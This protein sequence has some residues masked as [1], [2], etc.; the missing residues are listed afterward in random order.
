MDERSPKNTG[1]PLRLTS[2]CQLEAK[3]IS[4]AAL[5]EHMVGYALDLQRLWSTASDELLVSLCRT[6][7]GLYRYGM[8][9]EAAAEAEKKMAATP[10]SH[11]PE[12]PDPVKAT[13]ARLLTDGATLERGFQ[14]VLDAR[15]QHDMWVEAEL[16]EETRQQWIALLA[17]LPRELQAAGV[18]ETSRTMMRGNFGTHGS[19]HRAPSRPGNRLVKELWRPVRNTFLLNLVPG[20]CYRLFSNNVGP[21]SRNVVP[22]AAIFLTNVV[23]ST[24]M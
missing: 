14:A 10:H 12:L 21:F 19:A 11:S 9:M 13:V 15:P 22:S 5:L 18:S 7:P 17:G 23:P 1:L 4:D 8:R 2:A 24:R 16:L 3:G 20:R 6:Y